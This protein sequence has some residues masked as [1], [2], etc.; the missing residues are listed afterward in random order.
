MLVA[1]SVLV[2]LQFAVVAVLRCWLV[3]WMGAC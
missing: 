1:A 3:G 2:C